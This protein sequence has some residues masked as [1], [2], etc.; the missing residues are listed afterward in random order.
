MKQKRKIANMKCI[1]KLVVAVGNR[2]SIPLEMLEESECGS[3]MSQQR[4][5]CWGIYPY[6]IAPTYLRVVSRDTNVPR[7]LLVLC[8]NGTI[9]QHF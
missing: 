2:G 9:S 7:L 8:T 4:M 6:I 5:R 3:Y 1:I